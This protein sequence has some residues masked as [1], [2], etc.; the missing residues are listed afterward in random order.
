LRFGIS[1]DVIAI[2]GRESRSVI[3]RKKGRI[4]GCC[5]GGREVGKEEVILLK[6]AASK[7]GTLNA[8]VRVEILL[9]Q[10]SH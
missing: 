2:C 10:W 8:K 1:K 9:N 7:K 3:Q 4:R 6:Q 5:E